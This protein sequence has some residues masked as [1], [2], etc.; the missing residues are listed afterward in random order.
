MCVPHGLSLNSFKHQNSMHFYWYRCWAHNAFRFKRITFFQV[1]Q[2][3]FSVFIPGRNRDNE[4][5][6]HINKNIEIP[7]Q[8]KGMWKLIGIKLKE[9]S[10]RKTLLDGLSSPWKETFE[11][12]AIAFRRFLEPAWF[13]LLFSFSSCWWSSDNKTIHCAPSSSCFYVSVCVFFLFLSSK[14]LISTCLPIAM[15]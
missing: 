14:Y 12:W 9:W 2:S 6:N 13:H 3:C 10:R 5:K 8:S 15:T 4:K 1:D 7:K 11:K